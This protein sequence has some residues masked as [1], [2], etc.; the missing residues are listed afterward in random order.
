MCMCSCV[1]MLTYVLELFLLLQMEKKWILLSCR[2]RFNSESKQ[3]TKSQIQQA[4]GFLVVF[5]GRLE[6]IHASRPWGRK[7]VFRT[8]RSNFL[9]AYMWSEAHLIFPLKKLV[10]FRRKIKTHLEL[11]S[12]QQLIFWSEEWI[13]TGGFFFFPLTTWFYNNIFWEAW[14]V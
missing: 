5:S 8:L 6:S 11:I 4:V 3:L 13:C 1:Y 14:K 7:N 10:F 12:C 9:P 2:L